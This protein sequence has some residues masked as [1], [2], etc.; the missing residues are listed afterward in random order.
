LASI[1]CVIIGNKLKQHLALFAEN[2]GIS[3]RRRFDHLW[4]THFAHLHSTVHEVVERHDE[5]NTCSL[6]PE[7]EHSGNWAAGKRKW[8]VKLSEVSPL[9]EPPLLTCQ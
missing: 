3:L 4:S 6:I 7:E 9:A 1:L 8:N 2:I 5:P